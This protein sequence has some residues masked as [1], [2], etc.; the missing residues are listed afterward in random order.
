MQRDWGEGGGRGVKA[1]V[2]SPYNMERV[3]GSGGGGEDPALQ[4][5]T[6]REEVDGR[7]TEAQMAG[8]RDFMTCRLTTT[9]K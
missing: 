4:G 5:G 1:L 2:G 6:V 8:V 9:Q 3:G 7:L